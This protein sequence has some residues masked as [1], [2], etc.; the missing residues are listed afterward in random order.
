ML[1]PYLMP[2]VLQLIP[3]A[4]ASHKWVLQVKLVNKP[5]QLK[6]MTAESYGFVIKA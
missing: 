2:L 3:Y 5:H 1:P 4:P 6:V